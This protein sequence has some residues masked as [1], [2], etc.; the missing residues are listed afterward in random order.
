MVFLKR[1]KND[2]EGKGKWKRIG[3]GGDLCLVR[4][5]ERCV[6]TA[7]LYIHADCLKWKDVA[8]RTMPYSKCGPLFPMV[9]GGTQF[10]AKR[11]C[12]N[13]KHI[14]NAIARMLTATQVDDT[15]FTSKSMRKGGPST[16][17][18]AGLPRALQCQQSGHQG[19]AHKVYES[20]DDTD[21]ESNQ[22][23]SKH[24]PLGGFQ[25]D[26]LYRCLQMFGL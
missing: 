6:Q 5:I 15:G 1:Q 26:H 3:W 9:Y 21:T 16:A 14:T 8:M 22:D 12:I 13:A 25:K 11:E 10:N 7:Q 17:K 18:R 2:Q 20:D 19:N 23:L 4:R 24:E